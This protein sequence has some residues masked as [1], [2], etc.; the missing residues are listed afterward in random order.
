MGRLFPIIP[1]RINVR[2]YKNLSR[3][4]LL[5]V[6]FVSQVAAAKLGPL[7]LNP[8]IVLSLEANDNINFSEVEPL[9]DIILGAR[10]EANGTW[11]F[12]RVTALDF[13][14]GFGYEHYF[15][16]EDIATDNASISL[17]PD[18]EF[19]F[20]VHFSE[21][22]R[23]KISDKLDLAR[24]PSDIS[25][26]GEDGNLV[27]DLVRFDRIENSFTADLEWEMSSRNRLNLQYTRRDL[28]PFDD[29]FDS[30][31]RTHQNLS[32]TLQRQFSPSWSGGLTAGY[33]W[34]EYAINQQNDGDG[35]SVGAFANWRL[36]DF[37]SFSGSIGK[38]WNEFETNG[39]NGDFSDPSSWY[40]SL[41]MNHSPT[42]TFSYV[43]GWNQNES[44]GY[45]SN[46][47]LTQRV[48]VSAVWTAFSWGDLQSN[49]SHEWGDES[50]GFVEESY[51]RTFFTIGTETSLGPNTTFNANYRYTLKDSN[52]FGRSYE[53]N[54]ILLSIT[55]RF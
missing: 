5:W 40:W 43:V 39:R 3:F 20:E 53:Q 33:N 1:I 26:L 54:A 52:R 10:L 16:N 55:H 49:L 4:L 27:L 22:I 51:D 6:F 45:I 28:I 32:A 50:G 11:E 17:I 36:S 15:N 47:I 13:D 25:V 23:L 34:T 14:L 37:L 24:D 2:H 19:N 48:F 18:L 12:T 9:E 29:E 35:Y 44:L 41:E 38:S 8:R 7:E 46:T 30:T 42:R 31:E 21:Y